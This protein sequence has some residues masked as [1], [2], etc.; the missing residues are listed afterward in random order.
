M[1]KKS[2]KL[3]NRKINNVLL[4]VLSSLTLVNIIMC[5]LPYSLFYL[6]ENQ[7]LYLFSTMA[8]VIG[9]IFGLTLTAFVFFV[10]KFK[11]YARIDDTY[12]EATNSLLNRYFHM[13]III[14]VIC[15]GTLL[16]CIS[17]IIALHNL[18]SVF[19]FIIN[20]SVFLFAIGIAAILIFGI[21]LLDPDKLDKETTKMKKGAEEYYKTNSDDDTGSFDDFLKT[22]NLLEQLIISFA[23]LLVTNDNQYFKGYRPQIIQSLKVLS[24]NEIVN[25]KL[26]AEI[27][28]LRI[29]RN[30]LVHGTDFNVSKSVCNRLVQI[31]KAINKVFDI[32][33]NDNRGSQEWNDAMRELYSL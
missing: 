33:Q 24:I 14:A 30:G 16:F 20:E 13:L 27:N 2:N 29:Y 6:N 28:E 26:S 15:G 3:N 22:Y 5:I 10:E 21:V 9:G 1:D 4:V 32:F 23:K 7:L 19:P 8:Q 11:E 18:E 31:Y 12:Y 17:G 25:S